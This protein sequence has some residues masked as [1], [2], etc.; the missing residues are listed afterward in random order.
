MFEKE[1]KFSAQ[2]PN[3]LLAPVPIK[4][5]VPDWYKKMENY[6]NKDRLK[7]RVTIKKCVPF[8]DTLTSGYA[9]LN[10]VDYLFFKNN[11]GEICW[12]THGS[13]PDLSPWG[14]SMGMHDLE[15][16]SDDMI[17]LDEEGLPLKFENP[18]FISTPKNYSC[19]FTD[20]FNQGKKRKFRI[21]D[22]IVDTDM[23]TLPVN[24][25]FFLKQFKQDETVHIKKGE[26]I[27]LV[28]PFRREKWKMVVEK[29]K[30]SNT[31]RKMRFFKLIEDN[32]KKQAW[33]RKNY[34]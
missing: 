17:R 25:P 3:D 2:S 5:I 11:R 8:L 15:Q 23:Y 21:L 33:R 10:Q 34:D 4:K 22:G 13:L 7:E 27:A 20:P 32:Y 26:P 24:F 31:D 16:I 30:E 6:I 12:R 28:F 9:L 14:I 1:I 19:L 18:W 29:Q